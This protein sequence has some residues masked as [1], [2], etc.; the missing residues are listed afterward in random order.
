MAV[1]TQVSAE[2][3]AE[4]LMRYD[5]GKLVSL[6]GIAEGVENSNYLL[7][8]DRARF[9][10]TLYENRVNP[11]DLPYFHNL[12]AHLHNA[13]CPVPRFIDD[14]TGQWLQDVH[15]KK[16]CLIEFLPGISVSEP[17]PEQAHAVGQSLAKMHQAVGDFGEIKPNPLGHKSWRPLFDQCDKVAADALQDGFTEDIDRECDWLSANWPQDLSQC[18]V[19]TDLFPDNV[20]FRGD[21]VGGLIDFYFA[22]TDYRAYD[23]AVTHAAWSFTADGRQY[24]AGIGEALLAGYGEVIK[25]DE[26]EV[27]A[28]PS[29]ARGASLRFLLTRLYDWINTPADAMVT[30]KDPLAFYHRLVFYRSVESSK[31]FGGAP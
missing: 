28:F 17:T 3:A 1:Y 8:T 11:A 16:S 27:H 5:V 4:L 7:E 29:L 30:R 10:L 15:G 19:H 6:K 24:L 13:G 31:L 25:L 9:I 2:A 12:L 23:L 21:Q 20:L 22:C 18:A 26:A 14:S